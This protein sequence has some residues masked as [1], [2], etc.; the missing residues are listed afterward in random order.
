MSITYDHVGLCVTDLERSIAF[1]RDILGLEPSGR[2]FLPDD[3]TEQVAYHIGDL[4]FVLFHRPEFRSVNPKD[5]SG[6]DH[7]AFTMDGKTYE[8][9][10]AKLQERDLILRGPY[11][12]LGAYGRGLAT[13]FCDPDKNQIE[14]KTYDADLM[15]RYTTYDPGPLTNREL[16]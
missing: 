3:K 16:P 11:Q 8:T 10:L 13:Y 4:I 5:F 6:M 14:I 9:I 7:L 12:N 2:R 1:Y 15:A